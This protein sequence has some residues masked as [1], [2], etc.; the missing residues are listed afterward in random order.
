MKHVVPEQA[1]YRT[2]RA[3]DAWGR[4]SRF[5][6]DEDRTLFRLAR[7]ELPLAEQLLQFG[8]AGLGGVVDGGEDAEGIW[9]VRKEPATTLADSLR[10]KHTWSWR[11]AV[12][13]TLSIARALNA[14]EEARL[15]P[16]PLHPDGVGIDGELALL[17]AKS[18]ISAK[19][20]APTVP[21][22]SAISA[23][24]PLWTPPAQADGAPWDNLANRYAL[25]LIAYRLIAGSH[26]FSGAGLRHALAEAAHREAAPFVDDVA[27]E[28][29][30]GLQSFLLRLLSPREDE[31]PKDAA[32]IAQN[33]QRFLR[34]QRLGGLAENQPTL[35]SGESGALPMS[36]APDAPSAAA[37]LPTPPRNKT[38]RAASPPAAP[39]PK[40]T[41]APSSAWSS[42]LT[43]AWPLAAG[44]A[45]A[46]VALSFAQWDG[47][48]PEAERDDSTLS[49]EM[50]PLRQDD[51]SASDCASCHPRQAAEWRRSVMAHSVKSPLFNGLESLIQEQV[52]RD[53]NCPNG[54]GAL[55]R[56]NDRV[57]CRDEETGLP[58]SGSGGEHWCVNCHSPAE[59]LSSPMPAW[60]GRAGG[61]P[62]TRL[63]V[64]DMLDDRALEGISCGF[65]HQVSRPGRSTGQWR[66]RREPG[67]GIVQDRHSLLIPP[68]GSNR[69]A[70]HR[71]QRLPTGAGL[72]SH[73]AIEEPEQ[74]DP[75]P[76]MVH[77][78]PRAETKSYLRSSEFCGS[79]HDVRLFGTDV[80]G[81]RKGERFKRLRNAYTEWVDYAAQERR[82]GRD[83]ASC[84]DCHMSTFPGICEPG[85]SDD[86]TDPCPDG[87]RF[88][89]QKPGIRPLGR[90]A[91]NSSRLTPVTTHY[92]SG[93]DVPLSDEYPDEILNEDALDMHGLPISPVV[94]R[95]MLLRASMSL[96]LEPPTV[97]GGNI[98]TTVV[99]ENV[100]GGHKIPAGFSQEREIWVHLQV[101]DADGRSVYE[102]GRVDRPDQDL[103][104][105]RFI[106]VNTNPNIL[107]E[108]G[109]PA[110]LFGADVVDGP[111]HPEWSPPPERGGTSFRGKGL[112]N[113]QNGFLR[114]VTCIGIVSPT[115]ECLPGPGQ[116]FHRADRFADG[117]YDIDT[118]E[119]GSNLFGDNALFETYF[120][121]GSLDSTRGFPKAPDAIIDTR[122]LPSKIPVR[123]TY[124]LPARGRAPFTI[125]AR[126]LFRAFPPFLI[127]AFAN[128]EAEQ[129]RRG[130]RPSGPS[131]TLDMLQRLDIIELR[132]ETRETR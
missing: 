80:V 86:P 66:V 117:D 44:L 20:G 72:L 17:P 15:F 67:L 123:Y 74:G 42:R 113:F 81:A 69:Q 73:P 41:A 23:P 16:G 3:L 58:I 111:D 60:E 127:R 57:A 45:V 77:R 119:C 13:L 87:T 68:R 52:G 33:L 11:S 102:V 84:Q 51:T 47:P 90:V 71:Q 61:N 27:K 9:L 125:R 124:V 76:P 31:R 108:K 32:S 130:L 131:V 70:R 104:D 62:Q 40:K 53:E 78:R 88:V 115:G 64:R 19:L 29:P 46:A 25:G 132:R 129:A 38:N 7:S 37:P 93:V 116:G 112:I 26:P 101:T 98:G 97:R 10:R 34:G 95:D 63:P 56:T 30:S 1:G 75:T 118:G 105:K 91:E 43:R 106:R 5:E 24:S 85:E 89:S 107:D 100:G 14:A 28:L 55:R 18:L 79:C 121:V 110:G 128:Y 6:I 120:P 65:C 83:P 126:L 94:R 59:N 49:L 48:D 99:I 114:C 22:K 21:R 36:S 2:G 96:D 35:V 12:E 8:R 92:F 109:R 82:A 39:R 103:K 50:K 122:S 4:A 54:A